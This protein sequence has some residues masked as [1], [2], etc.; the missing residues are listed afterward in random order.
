MCVGTWNKGQLSNQLSNVP[1]MK[2]WKLEGSCQLQAVLLW[3]GFRKYI[4]HRP[5]T[6][7]GWPQLDRREYLPA[8]RNQLNGSGT[9]ISYNLLGNVVGAGSTGAPPL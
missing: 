5:R 1:H 9:V 6:M 4:P 7:H 2:H 8:G 3:R